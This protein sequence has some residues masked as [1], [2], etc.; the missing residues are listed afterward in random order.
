MSWEA[1]KA[2][3]SEQRRLEAEILAKQERAKARGLAFV[4][5][6]AAAKQLV[7]NFPKRFPY[8][9]QSVKDIEAKEL[10]PPLERS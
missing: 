2:M 3:W 10:A 6:Y 9:E 7:D 4:N 1:C 5:L 8:L